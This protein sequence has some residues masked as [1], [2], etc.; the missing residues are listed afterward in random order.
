MVGAVAKQF[1]PEPMVFRSAGISRG[2]ERGV[3]GGN[4]GARGGPMAMEVV[5]R[6]SKYTH[7]CTRFY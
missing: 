4:E 5:R 2:V 1:V 6:I 7:I 3:G